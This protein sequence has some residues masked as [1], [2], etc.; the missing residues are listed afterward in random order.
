MYCAAHDPLLLAGY[1]TCGRCRECS[2]PSAAA[3]LDARLIVATFAAGCEHVDEQTRVID[4]ARL[5]IES[6]CMATTRQGR[7]CRNQARDAGEPFCRVHAPRQV[8]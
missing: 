3:W 2:Y 4:P 1:L 8:R 7:R 5:V 6:R